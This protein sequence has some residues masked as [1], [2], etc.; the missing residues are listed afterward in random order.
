MLTYR[1]FGD[2]GIEEVVW[3][4][5]D[6]VVVNWDFL[7]K[8]IWWALGSPKLSEA[9]KS[10]QNYRQDLDIDLRSTTYATQ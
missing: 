9:R 4:V 3:W 1:L 6:V 8:S 2:H 5:V 10:W 7:M